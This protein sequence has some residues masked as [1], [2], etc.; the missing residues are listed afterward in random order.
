[1]LEHA[2]GLGI[3]NAHEH[4]NTMVDDANGL[5][6][7]LVATLVGRKY[8]L[9]RG[10]EEEQAVDTRFDHAV[11]IALERGDVELTVLGVGDDN[12][13]DDATI[14][15]VSH[16]CVLLIRIPGTRRASIIPGSQKAY[17]AHAREERRRAR[18]PYAPRLTAAY[19]P[20]FG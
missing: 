4:G 17:F 15:F 3:D 16:C 18:G 1:M 20:R 9:A 2:L 11:D 10:A 19:F 13:R 6:D 5:T 7:D 12:R 14:K 8:D